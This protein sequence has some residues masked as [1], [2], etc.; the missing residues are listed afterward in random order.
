[1]NATLER[2]PDWHGADASAWVDDIRR[3]ARLV[4]ASA[5]LGRVDGAALPPATGPLASFGS[6][7]FRKFVL[8][9]LAADLAV[10]GSPADM[11]DVERLAYVVAKH[12]TGF[13]LWTAEDA[14]GP[15]PVGYTGFY[16][17]SEASFERLSTGSPPLEDRFLHPVPQAERPFVYIF[18]F[19]IVTNLR[20]S[21][22]SDGAGQMLRA[23]DGDLGAANPRGL[24]AITVSPDGVRVCRRFGLE[25]GPSFMFE[26]E[27]EHAQVARRA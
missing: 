19:S 23:L 16:P 3:R 13:R 17:I 14:H 7:P 2:I 25:Q 24:S 1:V 9:L 18:N 6:A 12:P 22:G 10:Y 26:G 20:R 8:G 11:V 15:V 5:A 4:E 21:T 27:R